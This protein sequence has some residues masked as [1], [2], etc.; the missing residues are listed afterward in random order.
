MGEKIG[1]P[2]TEEVGRPRI[3]PKTLP[4][5][6][7]QEVPQEQ[8]EKEKVPTRTAHR[9]AIKETMAER[10]YNTTETGIQRAAKLL[11]ISEQQVADMVIT[12]A[13]RIERML[14]NVGGLGKKRRTTTRR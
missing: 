10:V 9:A 1:R 8:P 3:L 6:K 11:G 7:P 12:F 5:P 2:L 14:K 4:Q 13:D